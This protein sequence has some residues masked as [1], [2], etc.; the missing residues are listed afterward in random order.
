MRLVVAADPLVTSFF[1]LPKP[2]GKRI[3]QQGKQH[4]HLHHRKRLSGAGEW[5]GE[6]RIECVS[7]SHQLGFGRPPLGDKLVGVA[8]VPRI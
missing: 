4:A 3:N 6:K 7:P 5:T 2:E 8:K 1:L